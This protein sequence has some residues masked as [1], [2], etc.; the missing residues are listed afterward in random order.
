MA[1][2]K[3]ADERVG[4]AYFEFDAVRD[5]ASDSVYLDLDDFDRIEPI[6]RRHLRG[7]DYVGP[8]APTTREWA[9]LVSGLKKQT[10]N[11]AAEELAEWLEAQL[12]EGK[13]VY[14]NGV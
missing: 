7:F 11:Q 3:T 5:E 10:D 12:S 14:L 1:A 6:V 13:T 4:T 8:N 2:L 9:R